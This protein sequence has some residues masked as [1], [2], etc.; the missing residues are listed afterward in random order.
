MMFLIEYKVK[1]L[2]NKK[3][4]SGVKVLLSRK[5][6][7]LRTMYKEWTE[8]RGG[9]SQRTECPLPFLNLRRLRR[10]R[11]EFSN[12]HFM[13]FDTQVFENRTFARE[14]RDRL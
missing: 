3:K 13:T 10:N 5:Q 12:C 1:L 11:L 6:I 2:F 4:R 14:L 9:A 7:N 8:G